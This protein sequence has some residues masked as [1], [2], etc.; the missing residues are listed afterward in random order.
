VAWAAEVNSDAAAAVSHLNLFQSTYLWV[1]GA[2]IV[3]A[4][5]PAFFYAR[6]VQKVMA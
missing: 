5:V 2:I 3:F 6:R 1:L 4:V